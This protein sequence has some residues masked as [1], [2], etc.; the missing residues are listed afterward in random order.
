[1]S[2]PSVE[3]LMKKFEVSDSDPARNSTTSIVI[4]DESSS[5]SKVTQTASG[6]QGEK[7]FFKLLVLAELMNF[8]ICDPTVRE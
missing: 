8:S 2:Q 3:R 1:M 4:L 5:N 6:L 7:E